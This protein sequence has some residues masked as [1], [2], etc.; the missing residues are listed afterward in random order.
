MDL[1]IGVDGVAFDNR[2]IQI[3]VALPKIFNLLR[4]F[5]DDGLL[6][7]DASVGFIRVG[8]KGADCPV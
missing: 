4:L 2:V 1:G 3:V 6:Q 8:F 5:A 7:V